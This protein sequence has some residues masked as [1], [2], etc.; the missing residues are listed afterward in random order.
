MIKP[1]GWWKCTRSTFK[2]FEVGKVYYCKADTTGC[3]RIYPQEGS[4]WAPFWTNS[5]RFCYQAKDLD[6]EY[7]GSKP[8][9]NK[10]E[11]VCEY[12][13]SEVYVNGVLYITGVLK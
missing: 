1:Y 12:Q 11:V 13:P 10:L 3:P 7:L 4:S 6:F 5:N 9:E 8:K 2:D